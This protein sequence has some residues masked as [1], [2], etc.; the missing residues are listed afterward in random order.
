MKK[1]AKLL[2][3][4]LALFMIAAVMFACNSD[5][6]DTDKDDDK[7][8]EKY[9]K[10]TPEGVYNKISKAKDATITYTLKSDGYERKSVFTKNSDNVKVH[11]TYSSGTEDV[12][13]LNLKTG[14]AYREEDGQWFYEVEEGAV[15]SINSVFALDLAGEYGDLFT[16]E[17]AYESDN[18]DQSGNVYTFKS[19]VLEGIEM[20][21]I[22][23]TSLTMTRDGSVYTFVA[24]VESDG[25]TGT[26]EII[27]DFNATE[28]KFP[29]NAIE[30]RYEDY[31]ITVKDTNGN[32][33]KNVEINLYYGEGNYEDWENTDEEGK[34]VF[35]GIM[36]G[37]NYYAILYYHGDNDVEYV[38]EEKYNIGT[39][40][41]VI[42][43]AEKEKVVYTVTVTDENGLPIQDV[44]V[45]LFYAESNFY[46][47]Y[48]YTDA[49]G[50]VE[51]KFDDPHDY[52]VKIYGSLD[53]YTVEEKYYFTG[54][55]PLN[56]TLAKKVYKDYHVSFYTKGG[57]PLN[58]VY[59]YLYDGNDYLDSFSTDV[60]GEIT[61]RMEEKNSYKIVV[62][63]LPGDY[64]CQRE[65]GFGDGNS[66]TVIVG[67]FYYH[68]V[69]V[70]YPNGNAAQSVK[71]E[72][73]DKSSDGYSTDWGYTSEYGYT[74]VY[75]ND[76]KQY[77]L[78]LSNLPDGY[79]CEARYDTTGEVTTI[80]LIAID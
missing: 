12:R 23:I 38:F 57:S 14:D 63:Y 76:G 78:V 10:L 73:Y 39:T 79:T 9:T 49:N 34:A 22:K 20:D 52:Y 51:F 30:K 67:E 71:V 16:K 62:S 68:R 31:T 36:V 72:A 54:N 26:I 42:T 32:P 64:D 53:E 46:E 74:E 80:Y 48:G 4:I 35:S 8:T 28:V 43:I 25:E 59:I 56:I 11:Y 41:E 61:F 15:E 44:G 21:D 3:L 69:N 37:R 60:R 19:D 70:F 58:D 17:N 66:I 33:V 2:S 40:N 6:D 1:I 77:Y 65:I 13:Y 45:D 75:I 50:R 47:T 18:Y 7:P 24:N 55:D 5:A 29:E 27:V